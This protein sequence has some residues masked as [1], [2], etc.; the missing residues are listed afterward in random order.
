MTRRFNLYKSLN[1]NQ[2]YIKKT[3]LDSAIA[4]IVLFV[5]IY[6]ALHVFEPFTHISILGQATV[7][8]LFMQIFFTSIFGFLV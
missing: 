4:S 1:E 3:V 7:P 6:L 8:G 5:F 2:T